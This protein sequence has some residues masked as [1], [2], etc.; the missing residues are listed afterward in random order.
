ML[1]PSTWPPFTDRI[2]VKMLF[3]SFYLMLANATDRQRARQLFPQGSSK[4]VYVALQIVFFLYR[5]FA[6]LTGER[7]ERH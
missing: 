5:M 3:P 6:I 4:K 2:A 7:N 1:P